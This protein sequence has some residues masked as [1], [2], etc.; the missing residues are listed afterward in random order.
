M[1]LSGVTQL[2]AQELYS[3]SSVK[4]HKLGQIAWTPDGRK[5]QYTLAGELLVAG[6]WYQTAVHASTYV[7]QACPAVAAIGATTISVTVGAA[8]TAN[9][10]ADGYAIIS[11]GTGIGQMFLIK[12]HPAAASGTCVLTLDEPVRVALDTTSTIT[13]IKNA[14]D[15][16]VKWAV[17]QTGSSAGAAVFPV[18]SGEYGWLQTG[19]MGCALS[20]NV[21][22]AAETTGISPSTTTAGAITKAVTTQETIGGAAQVVTVSAAVGAI[23]IN[24]N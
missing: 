24:V 2:S 23:R 4:Q 1:N 21:A 20:D 5:F 14:F 22:T 3:S 15:S 18:A 12:S 10:F 19:G 11:A 9:Q 6:D 8:F 7:S 16:V 13:T 17:T